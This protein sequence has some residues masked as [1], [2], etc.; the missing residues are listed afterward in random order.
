MLPTGVCGR[1]ENATSALLPGL[2]V[3]VSAALDAE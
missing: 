3:D 2:T 1:G